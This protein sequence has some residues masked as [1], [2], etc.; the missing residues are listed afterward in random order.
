MIGNGLNHGDQE[1][2]PYFSPLEKS[3]VGHG[4]KGMF[5]LD[6]GDRDDEE[7]KE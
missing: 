6:P 1:F 7:K 5:G 2:F 3:V 4:A